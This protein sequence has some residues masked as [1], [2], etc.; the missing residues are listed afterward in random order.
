MKRLVDHLYRVVVILCAVALAATVAMVAFQILGRYLPFVQRALWTEELSRMGLV[1]LV[2]LGA[3]AGVRTSDHFLIDLIPRRLGPQLKRVLATLGLALVAAVAVALLVGSIPFVQT[4][5]G[6]T[7]TTSGMS[8]VY[9]YLAPA[10]SAVLM[11]V[12][13]IQVWWEAMQD[14]ENKGLQL[15]G[16]EMAE[17]VELDDLGLGDVP[18]AGGEGPWVR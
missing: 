3:A 12:F 6:R 15:R 2:F 9:T 4:G 10:V 8:L 16:T 17:Q 14:P 13:T 5:T 7:S 11:L 1:W 18:P